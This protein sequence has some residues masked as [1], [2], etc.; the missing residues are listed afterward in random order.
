MHKFFKSY[1]EC[2]AKKREGEKKECK[3][4]K[5]NINKRRSSSSLA[6]INNKQK[7]RASE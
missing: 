3:K 5:Q 2:R 1:D 4:E 7:E 6:K